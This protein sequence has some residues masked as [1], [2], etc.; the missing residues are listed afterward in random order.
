FMHEEEA[1]KEEVLRDTIA[2]AVSLMSWRKT[3]E[4]E[5]YYVEGLL[6]LD[7]LFRAG[8]LSFE[9]GSL[10]IDLGEEAYLRHKELYRERY[11]R[12]A[13][14][15]YICRRDAGEFLADYVQKEEGVWLP[16]DPE[17]RRFV[18]HYWERYLQIGQETMP[19]DE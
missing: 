19:F 8:V 7:I 14:E 10:G 6:H 9:G 13:G 3:G 16:K 12:L 5:P 11:T 18:D 2:R 1:L 4:V 17:V 15:W